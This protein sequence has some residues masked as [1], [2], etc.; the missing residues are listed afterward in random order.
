MM[1]LAS[2]GA[3]AFTPTA[4]LPPI[5]L[6]NTTAANWPARRAQL[7][8]LV[9][10]H[11]LGFV[12]ADTPS[13][14]NASIINS[15]TT[16]SLT[17]LYARLAFRANGTDVAF[18]VWIAWQPPA[19]KAKLPIFLTQWNHRS[20]AMTAVRRGFVGVVYPGADTRDASDAFR[21]AYPGA[22]FRKIL[23]RA[24]VASR[25][26]DVLLASPPP[27]P[28]LPPVDAS[29]VSITGHSRNGKQSLVA[30]AFDERITDVVGSSSGTPVAAPIRFSS[31][32][33]DGETTNYDTTKRDWFLESLKGYFG[34][35]D[36]V[37]A[38]GHYIL[39]MIAPRRCLLATALSDGSG[40]ATYAV[41]RNAGAAAAAYSLLGASDHLRVR[42]REGRHHGFIEVDDYMDW[43]SRVGDFPNV[44]LHAFDWD[45]WAAAAPPPPPP[46]PPTAPL[47]ARVRWLLGGTAAGGGGGGPAASLAQAYCEEANDGYSWKAELMMRDGRKCMGTGCKHGVVRVP[48]SFGSYVTAN[49]YLPNTTD[50]PAG[51]FP[52]V[53]FLHGYSYQLGTSSEYGLYE[54][55]K[56][57]L[58]SAIAARGAAVLAWDQ[59]GMGS[60]QHD[61]ATKFYARHRD[62]GASRLGAMVGEIEAALDALHC[63]APGAAATLPECADGSSHVPPYGPLDV[64]PLDPTAVHLLGYSMGS[65]IA[66][67]AAAL[68]PQIASVAAFGGWTPFGGAPAAG[69]GL[70][71]L[72]ETHAL[73]PRLGHFDGEGRKPPYDYAELIGAIAPRPALLYSPLR[74][75]FANATAV[76]AA[77][78]EAAAAWAAANASAALEVEAP[79]TPSDFRGP[80]VERALRWVEERVL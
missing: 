38:D 43:F 19:T 31:P 79:D 25:V 20:W 12:P 27:L 60:R 71:W 36:E 52:V 11:I 56:G 77:A 9:Q 2:L 10:Q 46:P 63:L 6:P 64:P 7:K 62:D 55:S 75:R 70:R 23:G 35:E 41:E 74:H 16:A 54:G 47:V 17:S 34:R 45:A 33:F 61:G 49:L 73:L 15:S 68:L 32:D 13:I 8:T 76:A 5:L 59:S 28:Q 30:A 14:L 44:T 72:Y 1:L 4:T 42:W 69:G 80:E 22:S 58:I 37:P 26:L 40:D 78:K 3:A 18:D 65:I 50:V 66:L 21:A 67:H 57:G 51:G 29:R 48:L 24:F 39:A 53:I